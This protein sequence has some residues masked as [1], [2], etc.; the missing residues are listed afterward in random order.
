MSAALSL[1]KA[2]DLERVTSLVARFHDEAGITQDEDTRR[3]AIAPLLD[4]SPYGAIYLIGP[5]A[6]PLGYIAV[7]FTWSLEFGGL[8]ATIDELFIRPNLRKRGIASEALSALTKALSSVGVQA[9][10]LE[11]DRDDESATR[12]YKRA[13]FEARDRFMLMSR[14]PS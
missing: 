11:V 1:A 8:D 3:A 5:R 7:T 12:L 4:Q 14:R 10:H 9:M 2:E 6:A 13:G